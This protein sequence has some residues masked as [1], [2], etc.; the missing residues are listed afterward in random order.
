MNKNELINKLQDI[1]WEDFEV[2]EAKTELPKSIWETISAFANT[3]GGWLVLGVKQTG[4]TFLIQGVANPEKI[5]SDLLTAI[6][7]GKFNKPIAVISKKYDIDGHKILA[8]YIPSASAKD[9]PV[10]YNAL[11]NTFI[12][13]GSG[14]QRA[15]KD[16]IDAMYRNSSFDKKDEELTEFTIADLD[17]ET[18]KRYRT[19]LENLNPQHHYN[20]FS[21]L[22]LLEKLRVIVN[23]KVTNG[24][25]LVF[26]TE[27]TI[28]SLCTDFRIDYLEVMG[29]SYSDAPNRYEYRLPQE[30][31]LFN[32]YFGIYERLFKKIDIPFKLKGAFRD[33]NQPQLIAIRE[34]LVNLLIH[35]DYF[36]LMKPRIRVFLDR[37]EFLNP[38]CL[39]KDINSIIKEEFSLPRN[40]IIAKIFRIIKLSENIGSGFYKMIE[41]WKSYYERSPEIEGD[42]DWYKIQFYFAQDIPQIPLVEN[43]AENLVENLVEK[44]KRVLSANQERIIALMIEQPYISKKEIA[45][46]LE[47]SSTTIDNNIKLLKGMNLVKRI[48]S[49][50]GGYWEVS[51]PQAR[52]SGEP[53]SDR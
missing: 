6:R 20:Q 29:T 46:R 45:E 26:G 37:I 42:F 23:G 47:V 31:N 48:G 3:A 4:K 13:T 27:D 7:S 15:T 51:S 1:E 28:N 8:F 52:K 25:L 22:E 11:H 36:S 43:L 49:D 41:G 35:T 39:P 38:G 17:Q 21:T 32:Y 18:V 2:K 9:K 10:Y 16:E 50:K 53:S 19:Y 40:P 24:G 5:E 30:E 33:E 12:R 34:A 44:P 14:D